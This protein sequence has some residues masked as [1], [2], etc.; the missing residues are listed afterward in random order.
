VRVREHLAMTAPTPR[1]MPAAPDMQARFEELQ[2]RLVD[3]W[4]SMHGMTPDPQT[5]VVVPSLSIE[6]LEGSG[7][8]MAP[9][10]E[11]YLF[12]L[13]LLRQPLARMVYVTSQPIHPSVVDYYLSLVPDVPQSHARRRLFTVPVL[14]GSAQP[15]SAKLLE[16]PRLLE[17]IRGLIP[18]ARRAHLV[19][20]LTTD[21]ERDLAVHLGIPMYGADPK[22]VDFGT[23]SGSRRL[24]AD[25]GVP[26][27]AGVEH[28]HSLDDVV[29][30]ILALRMAKPSIAQVLVKLN[31]G[32]SGDGNALVDL[33]GAPAPGANGERAAVDQAV[34]GMQ[35]EARGTPLA[36][37]EA[38]LRAHGGVVEERI[39][40]REFTSPSV[41][42]RAS[43]LGELELLSTHD[44]LLGG[45]S[46]QAYLGCVFPANS[47]YAALIT[48]EAAKIGRR[49]V[50]EGVL[51]RFALDFVAVRN[52]TDAWEAYA[53][54]VNLRK[55]GTT[56]PFLTLQ[57]LTDGVYD[58]ERAT[59]T[60][61]SG[62]AKFLV[63]SDHVD[64]SDFRGLTP[65]DVFDLAVRHG[66][67]YNAQTET[68]VVFHMLSALSSEGHLG[69]T[70]IGDSHEQARELFDRMVAVLE[71]DA[72]D[73]MRP[74][75]LPT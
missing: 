42:M 45:P 53:I 61:R 66:L 2:A 34:R 56:H 70:A 14:D 25:E 11:R 43:P 35:L 26:H 23:K 50:S 8:V 28:L 17:R 68:G 33:A 71:A 72:A 69:L 30:A 41:Q 4:D 20:F 73:A 48:E 10:E 7:L 39:A 51:G 5:I 22:F 21:L 55:G 75:P 58:P 40:G 9:Y 63:A 37:Y 62:R 1:D 12:L 38:A 60:V 13:F 67:H 64:S 24:F 29:A 74:R 44:Q 65:D 31:E 32:V 57:Y 36:V 46:G 6:L 16:R 19:P 52:D 59:F 47:E 3:L 15:L 27:P 18:D 49:L 54:E